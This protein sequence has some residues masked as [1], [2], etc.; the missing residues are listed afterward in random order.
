MTAPVLRVRDLEVRFGAAGPVAVDGLSYDLHAGETLGIVGESGSGKTMALRALLR[1]SPPNAVL[2]G[3]VLLGD[4]DL[5]QAPESTMARVRGRSIAM[6]FQ[7]PT[8][9]FN[10]VLSVGAQVAEAVRV[11][12]REI[13]RKAAR[14]RA[15]DLLS[16]VGIPAAGVRYNQFPHEYSGGMRQRAM[17]AMAIANEPEILL[18]DEPTTAL[19]VTVQ[20]QILDLLRV[21]QEETGA[22]TILVTH[23]LGVIAEIADRVLVM[24]AGRAVEAAPVRSIFDAPGHPYTAA[25]LA[26]RPMLADTVRRLQPIP[27]VIPAI[28]DLPSGC[29]FHPRCEIGRDDD[30]CNADR[31]DLHTVVEGHS[32][33]CHH[34]EKL[35]GPMTTARER[36]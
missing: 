1:L 20:A 16:R 13:S 30:R 27:G 19:D 26:S 4:Q 28:G 9:Y 12:H 33:A 14:Q 11:H 31:P 17:I 7:D 5:L 23:D 8:T 3:Q 29:A 35:L 6:V 25:L 15:V 32:S 24:Y 22:A 36:S 10:P 18:A 21:A 34:A 2:K